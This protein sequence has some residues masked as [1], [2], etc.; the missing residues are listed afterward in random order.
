MR[1]KDV[2]E[3]RLSAAELQTLQEEAAKKKAQE[4]KAR[5][6]KSSKKFEDSR[7]RELEQVGEVRGQRIAEGGSVELVGEY[8][9]S[10]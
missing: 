9:P 6:G 2:A 4:R 8:P 3:H 5:E 1:E 7:T 10:M